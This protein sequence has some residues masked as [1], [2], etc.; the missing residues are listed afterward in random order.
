[1]AEP[2]R[3]EVHNLLGFIAYSEERLEDAERAFEL[4]FALSGGADADAA[5]NLK[6]VRAALAERPTDDFSG[7]VQQLA[8]G[9]FGPAVDPTLLGS[10]LAGALGDEL[11]AA[12]R[13][14]AVGGLV[15]RAALPAALRL[16]AV[17]RSR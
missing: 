2:G 6:A 13:R 9:H 5:A 10:L 4:A 3:H 8:R 14:A 15:V 7:T 17:G 16:T 12:H 1:M 11:S